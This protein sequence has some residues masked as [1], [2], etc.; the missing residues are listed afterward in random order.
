MLLFYRSWSLPIEVGE[1]CYGLELQQMVYRNWCSPSVGFGCCR[2]DMLLVGHTLPPTQLRQT[3]LW[4]SAL[5]LQRNF[6]NVERFESK[7]D[8]LL[9]RA[10]W[11]KLHPS[12]L[13][14]NRWFYPCAHQRRDKLN[15]LR[16]L[17]QSAIHHQFSFGVRILT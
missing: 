17:L 3:A 13:P 11:G 2:R 10:F 7:M 15:Q 9:P 16:L 4:Q 14:S 1:I 8:I 5:G 12:T 6:S